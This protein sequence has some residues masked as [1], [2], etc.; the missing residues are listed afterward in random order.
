MVKFE[1]IFQNLRGIIFVKLTLNILKR[2]SCLQKY[3]LN[4]HHFLKI[5]QT[6]A[7]G[8]FSGLSIIFAQTEGR[9]NISGPREIINLLCNNKRVIPSEIHINSSLNSS[10]PCSKWA[11]LSIRPRSSQKIPVGSARKAARKSPGETL[12]TSRTVIRMSQ[13][14]RRTLQVAGEIDS[15]ERQS[16][17]DATDCRQGAEKILAEDIEQRQSERREDGVEED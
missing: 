9:I 11:A 6:S 17:W 10:L 16:L 4:F 3:R 5:K 15:P 1:L 7:L 14:A 8:A 13:A 12:Q 2:F